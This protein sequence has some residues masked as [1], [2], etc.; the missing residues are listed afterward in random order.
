[1]IAPP[2]RPLI[3]LLALSLGLVVGC[4]ANAPGSTDPA[5]DPAEVRDVLNTPAGRTTPGADADSPA[6]GRDAWSIA[7]AT[8]SVGDHRA[9]AE[10]LQAQLAREHDLPGTTIVSEADRSILYYGRYSSPQDPRLQG[11]LERIK[12]LVVGDRQ[13]FVSAFLVPPDTL[14]PGSNSPYSLTSV[15][16]RYGEDAVLYTLE[17]G[18]YDDPDRQAAMQA[19]EEAVRVYRQQ[20]EPAYFYH[21]P[22]RSSVTIGV[23]EEAYVDLAAPGY[24]PHV[25]ELKLRHPHRAM[26]GRLVRVSEAGRDKGTASSKLMLIP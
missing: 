19:A 17:V 18:V 25:R 12:G 3:P 21:G 10:A 11:D 14:A 1:M 20:G 5:Y 22:H 24:G 4:Q 6:A 13:P 2:L 8:F 15:R 23:L 7:L 26:N 9:G 16:K